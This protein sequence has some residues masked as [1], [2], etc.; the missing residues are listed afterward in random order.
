MLRGL[1]PTGDFFLSG[2]IVLRL[3]VVSIGTIVVS[4]AMIFLAVLIL[5]I[6]VLGVGVIGIISTAIVCHIWFP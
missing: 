2:T 3:T 1:Q 5:P 4:R 6:T